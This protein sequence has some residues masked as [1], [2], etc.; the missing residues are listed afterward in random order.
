MK[1]WNKWLR[2]S[3]RWLAVPMFI[4]IPISVVLRVSGNGAIMAG[5]PQWEMI[6]SLLMLFL[7]ISG[8][9]LFFVPYWTKRKRNQRRKDGVTATRT[10]EKKG[11]AV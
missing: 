8:A 5:I 9:Y 6:Q 4:L 10:S 3:H 11:T 7:A 1:S 2:K